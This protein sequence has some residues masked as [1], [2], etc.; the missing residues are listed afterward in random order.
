M[1]EQDK[2]G[3]V[4]DPAEGYEVQGTEEFFNVDPDET[5]ESD[6]SDVDEALK[7]ETDDGKG[8]AVVP[9]EDFDSF[10]TDGVENDDSDKDNETPSED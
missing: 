6:D 10:A 7:Q 5:A 9:R 4:T 8:G 1:T 2:S 3:D